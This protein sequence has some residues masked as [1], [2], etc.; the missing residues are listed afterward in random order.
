MK[1]NIRL[2]PRQ[3]KKIIYKYT[4]T[5]SPETIDN[6]ATLGLGLELQKEI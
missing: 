4:I 5:H 2:S 3:K 6:L 1:L